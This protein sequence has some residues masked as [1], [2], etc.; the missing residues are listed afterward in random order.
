MSYPIILFPF[1][2][3]PTLYYENPANYDILPGYLFNFLK[4]KIRIN[5]LVL[6]TNRL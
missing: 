2:H 4:L 5:I 1:I 6:L 3:G